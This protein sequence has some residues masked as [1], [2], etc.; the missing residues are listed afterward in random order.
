MAAKHLS[1]D[2]F[3]AR[4][5]ALF[6]EKKPK[7]H[8]SIY[9]VQKRLTYGQ[10]IPAATIEN[11]MPDLNLAKPLPVIVRA[12]NGKSKSKRKEKIKLS[13]IVQPGELEKF[14]LRYADICKTGMVAL[15][16]R[17][18]SKKKAKAKKKKSAAAPA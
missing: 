18:R 13:T 12:T 1:N 2:D 15:K 3:F 6:D 11:P 8:G 9:L 16:P 10:E 5:T 7:T 14:Y 4:L 17:D